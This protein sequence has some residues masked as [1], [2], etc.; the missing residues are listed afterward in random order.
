MRARLA[1]AV[2]SLVLGASGVSIDCAGAQVVTLQ[3]NHWDL[4]FTYDVDLTK[5]TIFMTHMGQA[6]RAEVSD[7]YISWPNVSVSGAK[8]RLD[9]R[10]GLVQHWTYDRSGNWSWGEAGRCSRA[11]GDIMKD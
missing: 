7:R 1:V 2:V 9:R 8:F 10:T 6:Y 5:Q 3:C 4:S 11:G